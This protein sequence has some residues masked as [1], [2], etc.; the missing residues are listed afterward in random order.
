MNVSRTP[1]FNPVLSMRVLVQCLQSVLT[2][3]LPQCCL[4]RV[5][6]AVWSSNEG[7]PIVIHM[8]HGVS[9]CLVYSWMHARYTDAFYV[10]RQTEC[11]LK[12]EAFGDTGCELVTGQSCGN[13]CYGHTR[14]DVRMA[15]D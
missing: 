12:C 9:C 15:V 4:I 5:D 1:V 7:V 6:T 10:Q 14:E 11:L 8:I 2:F 3:I 13:G